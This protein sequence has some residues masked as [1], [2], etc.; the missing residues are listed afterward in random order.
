MAAA[1]RRRL[2]IVAEHADIWHSFS[3]PE[4]LERK[5]GILAEHG[6]AVGRDTSQIETSTELR[7]RTPEQADEFVAL[8]ATLFTLGIS[9]P[10]YDL[11]PVKDWLAWRDHHN[12]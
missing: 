3:D 4:T 7:N 11:S 8:G 1:R 6:A 5:L 12:S 9:G 10:D 2:R